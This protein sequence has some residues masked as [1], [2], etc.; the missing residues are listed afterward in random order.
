MPHA[1]SAINLLIYAIVTSL[2]KIKHSCLFAIRGVSLQLIRKSNCFV[3]SDTIPAEFK[4]K[5]LHS[6]RNKEYKCFKIALLFQL[7]LKFPLG[8]QQRKVALWWKGS[9]QECIPVGCVPSVAVSPSLHHATHASLHHAHPPSPRMPPLPCMPPFATHPL[10]HA[11]PLC[12]ACTLHH[13]CPPFTMHA[14]P[15]VDRQMLM[16]TLHFRNYCYGW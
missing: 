7:L 8:S 12:H 1:F 5:V 13:A 10:C 2:N 16:K 14:L 6:S 4:I 9:K 3:D 15:P 11:S